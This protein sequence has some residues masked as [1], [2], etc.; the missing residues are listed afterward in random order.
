MKI[1]KLSLSALVIIVAAG[2]SAFR[3]APKGGFYTTTTFNYTGST[4][5][6][7]AY[8]T[9]ANYTKVSSTSCTNG[10]LLCSIGVTAVTHT[11]VHEIVT[12]PVLPSGTG[13]VISGLNGDGSKNAVG[14][15]YSVGSK[16][17]VID[18]EL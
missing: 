6:K 1:I 11:A 4:Q 9:P 2:T 7:G 8:N 12:V 16:T 3:G 10:E 14:G 18:F 5:T 17:V 15:S 13:T